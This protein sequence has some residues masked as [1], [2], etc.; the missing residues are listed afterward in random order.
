MYTPHYIFPILT[1]EPLINQDGEPTTPHKL[2]TD[3][4]YSLSNPPVLFYHV[5]YTKGLHLLTE[6]RYVCVN[7]HK[8]VFGVYLL[9]FYTKKGT[10][11]MYLLHEKYF[12]HMTFYLTKKI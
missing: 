8:R 1:I 3:I 5:L 4:K 6:R 2:P 9:E 10:S 12:I 7:N 11:Y